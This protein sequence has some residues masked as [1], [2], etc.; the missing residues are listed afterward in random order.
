MEQV[1]VNGQE[2]QDAELFENVT[3]QLRWFLVEI[4]KIPQTTCCLEQKIY[5]LKAM[6]EFILLPQ[7]KKL[8]DQ[9][10]RFNKL[11]N[12]LYAKVWEFNK[13]PYLRANGGLRRSE[14]DAMYPD[15]GK[16][17]HRFAETLAEMECYLA[18]EGKMR[19]RSS[20]L[21]LE[22]I[23]KYLDSHY[24]NKIINS[25]TNYM[26]NDNKKYLILSDC[27][28]IKYLFRSFPNCVFSIKDITHLS[29]GNITLENVKN[30]L[31]DFYL[32]SHSEQIFN[33]SSLCH[34][35]SFSEMCGIIYGIPYSKEIINNYKIKMAL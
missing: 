27:N 17:R 31:I 29:I 9:D 23:N 1:V 35:S 30:T 18:K 6:F 20:R 33:I 12:T 5:A 26:K 2:S 21:K 13:T 10:K 34:G 11:K 14:C 8:L 22:N 7:V 32:M 16:L 4:D 24:A 15:H 28:E 3:D 25:F 19:R